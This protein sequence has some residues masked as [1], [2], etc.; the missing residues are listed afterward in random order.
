MMAGASRAHNDII[1][2]LTFIFKRG[3]KGGICKLYGENMAVYFDEESPQVLPDIKIVCDR[4]KI[5]DDKIYG[6][7]DFIVEILS[8]STKK[9]DLT[10]KKDLYERFGVRE[11]WIIN[12]QDKSVQVYLLESESEE[13]KYVLDYVYHDFN[14][15]YIQE[16]LKYGD[17]EEQ[18]MVK[19]KTIKTSLYGN[20][21]NKGNESEKLEINISEIFEDML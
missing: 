10:E 9:K 12:P 3:L 21:G 19:I 6:A 7:P 8:P 16:K 17:D 2:N 13:G 4:N 20:Y 18:E 14:E 5:K 15:E 11:Y 1:G